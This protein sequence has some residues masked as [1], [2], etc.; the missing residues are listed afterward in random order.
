VPTAGVS[1]H[2]AAALG[3]EPLSAACPYG[4]GLVF[5]PGW[6]CDECA[7]VVFTDM[8]RDADDEPDADYG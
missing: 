2:F 6:F 3:D 5:A 4:H 8:L 7:A 1:V